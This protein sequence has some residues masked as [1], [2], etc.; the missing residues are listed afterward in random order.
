MAVF[1]PRPTKR[2]FVVEVLGEVAQI[3]EQRNCDKMVKFSCLFGWE[4][5]GERVGVDGLAEGLLKSLDNIGG[6][7]I[8]LDG[9]VTVDGTESD[10]IVPARN[11]VM[12]M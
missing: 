5:R 6:A 2:C 12:W 3:G 4:S 9:D 1:Q 8:K 7:G 11:D 10:R